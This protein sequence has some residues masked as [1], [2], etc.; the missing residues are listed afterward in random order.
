MHTC[1]FDPL[2]G[3]NRIVTLPARENGRKWKSERHA[4][5]YIAMCFKM[6]FTIVVVLAFPGMVNS[7]SFI[8]QVACRQRAASVPPSQLLLTSPCSNAVL[9]LWVSFVL[10]VDTKKQTIVLVKNIKSFCQNL[11]VGRIREFENKIGIFKEQF[12]QI[13]KVIQGGVRSEH[14]INLGFAILTWFRK[15][16]LAFLSLCESLHEK[17]TSSTVPCLTVRSTGSSIHSNF[18][19]N[20]IREKCQ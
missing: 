8:M 13:V 16:H 19:C 10:G 14:S 12:A 2:K 20:C 7:A 18:S 4:L 3:K 15:Y 1:K 9:D 5:H 17:V 6:I 11:Q